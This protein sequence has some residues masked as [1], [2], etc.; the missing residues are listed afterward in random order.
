MN[1]LILMC[2]TNSLEKQK[3]IFRIKLCWQIG[4]QEVRYSTLDSWR[5]GYTYNSSY[6]PPTQLLISYLILG[7]FSFFPCSAVK[8]QFL[9]LSLLAVLSSRSPSHSRRE[10]QHTG[11]LALKPVQARVLS[12]WDM[13]S[14]LLC[15]MWHQ[16]RGVGYANSHIPQ[17][18]DI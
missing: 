15:S 11:P 16:H 12:R 6:F 4:L 7:L 18:K 17:W 10:Q 1:S 14:N 13:L 3:Y 8:S 9:S 5:R 2:R